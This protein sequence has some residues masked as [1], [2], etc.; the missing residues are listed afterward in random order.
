MN[1]TDRKLLGGS[2][3]DLEDAKSIIEVQG[4]RLNLNLVRRLC[5]SQLQGTLDKIKGRDI[6]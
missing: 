5:P 1:L 6:Q 2:A 4:E 3:H